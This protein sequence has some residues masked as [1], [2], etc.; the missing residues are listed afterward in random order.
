MHTEETHEM[1][2]LSVDETGAE[3]WHCPTCGRRFLMRWPPD[4]G[5]SVLTPG[6][7]H[8]THVGGKGGLHMGGA[9]LTETAPQSFE[10]SEADGPQ[11]PAHIEALWRKVLRD[12]TDEGS[13][14][15]QT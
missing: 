4:Y 3:E 5:R 13:S 14:D 12:I 11:L 6:D 7:E 10:A 8:V 9:A 2:L 15:S 1:E